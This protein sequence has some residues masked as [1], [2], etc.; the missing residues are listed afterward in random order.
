VIGKEGLRLLLFFCGWCTR[1][2]KPAQNDI[3][4][5]H[6]SVYTGWLELIQ[7]F[8]IMS[9]QNTHNIIISYLK[10]YNPEFIGLF[11]S[12][13]RGESTVDSD[14]D[15]LI[16]FQV[17]YSLLQLIKIENELSELL[18]KKVDL[19]TEGAIKNERIRQSIQRDLQ[20]I[21]EA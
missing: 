21:F 11:G 12:F 13:A 3:T 20:I 14:I 1:Q 17:T 4:G 15:I 5:S 8:C 9:M 18:E 2:G 19:V 10:S 6:P 7:Y 16:R